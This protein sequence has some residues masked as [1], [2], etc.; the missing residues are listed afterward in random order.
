MDRLQEQILWIL[1]PT[2]V[3]NALFTAR[4]FIALE[5]PL[6]MPDHLSYTLTMWCSAMLPFVIYSYFF[7]GT[8]F[9]I[10][11]LVMPLLIFSSIVI[12]NN[13]NN[14]IAYFVFHISSSMSW[15]CVYNHFI[16]AEPGTILFTILKPDIL[17]ATACF[18]SV[19]IRSNMM[20]RSHII[21]P[22][23]STLGLHLLLLYLWGIE[24]N[25]KHFPEELPSALSFFSP[26][27][28]LA[29]T[30]LQQGAMNRRPVRL[31]NIEQEL[32][33]KDIP[34]TVIY[35]FML[36]L[37]HTTCMILT[38][39]LYDTDHE[40][41]D[42][43]VSFTSNGKV[44][45]INADQPMRTRPEELPNDLIEITEEEAIRLTTRFTGGQ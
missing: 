37:S 26:V 43:S 6:Y 31:V 12:I 7:H 4:I 27:Y 32:H 21:H 25:V 15:Y 10:S 8:Y 17:F 5:T 45:E 29:I 33:I 35:S 40:H 42:S 34:F 38:L 23:L 13:K 18:S 22:A 30:A 24:L 1:I 28:K 9:D 16:N 11:F 44:N 3:I 20:Y 19:M 41:K 36:V 39:L 2:F 14:K